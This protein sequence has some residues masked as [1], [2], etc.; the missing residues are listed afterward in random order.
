MGPKELARH[1]FRNGGRIVQPAYNADE[2]LSLKTYFAG[3]AD[4]DDAP[5]SKAGI[6]LVRELMD[7][8]VLLDV[9]HVGR[10][11]A[12]DIIRL[13]KIKN[14]PVTAN[15]ANAIGVF[16]DRDGSSECSSG[17]KSRNH[18]DDVICGVAQTGGVV[19]ITPIRFMFKP[20]DGVSGRDATENDFIQHLD[21]VAKRLRCKSGR[22]KKSRYLD[23]THHVGL[24]SDGSTNG[25]DPK[26]GWLH[27]EMANRLK[28]WQRIATRLKQECDY[29]VKEIERIIGGNFERVYR[30][31]LPGVQ[32]PKIVS[33]KND[34]I[35]SKGA[36]LFKWKRPVVNQPKPKKAFAWLAKPK[37][38]RIVIER[39][40]NG[41]FKRFKSE[42]AGSARKKKMRLPSGKYRWFVQAKRGDLQVNSHW[43]YFEVR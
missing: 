10:K 4:E 34:A 19:G 15:H 13:G 7:R 30:E 14:R 35:R 29:S 24:S 17:C 18:D 6:T 11:S 22:G 26:V 33:P 8:Y 36:V 40:L 16:D 23:M 21:Y 27:M 32:R 39:K 38:F 2:N 37:Q 31:A 42:E 25:Y 9:S 3:G 28:R 5:L 1:F 12:L 41:R 20:W 43:G